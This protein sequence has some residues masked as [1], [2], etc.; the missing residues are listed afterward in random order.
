MARVCSLLGRCQ[1]LPSRDSG[2]HWIRWQERERRHRKAPAHLCW[3][4]G[5]RPKGKRGCPLTAHWDQTAR[6]WSCREA[7]GNLG[8]PHFRPSCTHAGFPYLRLCCEGS[9]ALSSPL[10]WGGDRARKAGGSLPHCSCGRGS[11]NPA[12]RKPGIILARIPGPA[13][14]LSHRRG[15]GGEWTGDP[16]FVPSRKKGLRVAFS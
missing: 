14:A 15:Q 10:R 11:R 16:K 4:L 1:R 5:G 7:R 12:C 8:L 13:G 6:A 2:K 3:G 9:W